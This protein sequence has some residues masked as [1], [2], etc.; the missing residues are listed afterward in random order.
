M[1]AN[2]C[3]T[4]EKGDSNS[5]SVGVEVSAA[6]VDIVWRFTVDIVWRLFKS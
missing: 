3:V 4:V 1:T 2:V 5:L 6:T